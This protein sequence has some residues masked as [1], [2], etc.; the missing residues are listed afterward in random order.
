MTD[1]VLSLTVALPGMSRIIRVTD[2]QDL[3]GTLRIRGVV[4]DRSQLQRG[5]SS[6]FD[7]LIDPIQR[8]ARTGSFGRNL[9]LRLEG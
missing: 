7:L 2:V 1:R 8:L 3:G 6:A 9:V 4:D 5:E